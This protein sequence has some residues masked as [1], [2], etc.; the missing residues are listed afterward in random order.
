MRQA[1][2]EITVSWR[3]IGCDF[4]SEATDLDFR[5]K[6]VYGQKNF[7]HYTHCIMKSSLQ[8]ACECFQTQTPLERVGIE[9]VNLYSDFHCTGGIVL[10]Q[11]DGEIVA[12]IPAK[13]L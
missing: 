7:P 6:I 9:T 4:L 12:I 10:L 8:E 3:I 11:N 5:H 13:F 2:M 1:L